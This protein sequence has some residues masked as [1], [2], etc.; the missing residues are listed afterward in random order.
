MVTCTPALGAVWRSRSRVTSDNTRV[1]PHFAG[2]RGMAARS[3]PRAPRRRARAAYRG[4]LIGVK[5]GRTLC[6]RIQI[7]VRLNRGYSVYDLTPNMSSLCRLATLAAQKPRRR[8]PTHNAMDTHARNSRTK[9]RN[10]RMAHGTI[11]KR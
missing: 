5:S 2:S 4:N 11:Q 3:R 6:Q 10:T 7:P 1:A 8:S 9:T